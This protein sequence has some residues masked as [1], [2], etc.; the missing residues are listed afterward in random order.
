MLH[1]TSMATAVIAAQERPNRRAG[2]A[3]ERVDSVTFFQ[4]RV[5]AE[6]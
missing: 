3:C 4:E 5:A 6:L 2:F 1:P